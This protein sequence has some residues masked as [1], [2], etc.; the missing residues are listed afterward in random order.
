M[1][2]KKL[3]IS[4]SALYQLK[5]NPV[6]KYHLNQ[7]MI[8]GASYDPKVEQGIAKIRILCIFLASTL[9]LLQAIKQL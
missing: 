6:C 7:W 8:R 3:Y 5:L 9:S 1:H 2:F 4:E